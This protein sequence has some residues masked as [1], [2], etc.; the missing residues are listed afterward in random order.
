MFGLAIGVLVA[1]IF[2]FMGKAAPA[3]FFATS[4]P[5]EIAQALAPHLG[6][7][8][9]GNPIPDVMKSQIVFWN[10]GSQ[11]I[12]GKDISDTEPIRFIPT[13]AVK[14]L[15]VRQLKT[16]RP[17]LNF[18]ATIEDDETGRGQMV[19]LRMAGDDAL[20]SGEGGLF[21]VLYSG[22]PDVDF[23]V[24]AR[25]KGAPA[26]FVRKSWQNIAGRDSMKVIL[27][28]G[29]AVVL[30][31][32]SIVL[33]MARFR[34]PKRLRSGVLFVLNGVVALSVAIY[35]LGAHDLRFFGPNWMR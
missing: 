33:A 8:W 27:A 29:I 31:W 23:N 21:Q 16:A 30:G 17:D 18:N 10:G 6:V 1:A 26:G 22:D 24:E 5:E 7:T 34:E 13:K 35:M 4:K 2:Y 11:Y 3:P 9:D 28:V 25:I 14:I 32:V 20:E 12:D 15:A 19:Q